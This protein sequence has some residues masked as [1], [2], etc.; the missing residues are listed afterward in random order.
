[1]KFFALV[2]T[3]AVVTGCGGGLFDSRPATKNLIGSEPTGSTQVDSASSGS[4]SRVDSA[5]SGSNSRNDAAANG[6]SASI[7]GSEGTASAPAA[8]DALAKWLEK[9]PA[10]D[11]V[12]LD[13]LIKS[14]QPFEV[15]CEIEIE[16]GQDDD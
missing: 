10:A 12:I 9:C 13:A 6:A 1:M 3:A 4:D 11:P 5:A 16:V 8:N 15:E 14:G 2:V 7:D